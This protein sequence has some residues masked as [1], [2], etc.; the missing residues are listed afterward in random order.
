MHRMCSQWFEQGYQ[1]PSAELRKRTIRCVVTL[2]ECATG[3][4]KDKTPRKLT[5]SDAEN[6]K[7]LLICELLHWYYS[8]ASP[9]WVTKLY[10]YTKCVCVCMWERERDC[11]ERA[12]QGTEME[13]TCRGQVYRPLNIYLILTNE[14]QGFPLAAV[15]K[16]KRKIIG[17]DNVINN[18]ACRI[19][20]WNSLQVQQNMLRNF[21]AC[22]AQWFNSPTLVLIKFY[23]K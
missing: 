13:H 7:N 4:A 18:W 11:P 6:L 8:Y 3:H 2:K 20:K 15:K 17:R 22:I 1:R 12:V 21:S 19:V 10:N 9:E 16:I 5:Q 14:P 23:L